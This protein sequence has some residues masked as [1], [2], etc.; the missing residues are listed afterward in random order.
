LLELVE[1]ALDEISLLVKMS[2]VR[3]LNLAVSLWRND[4]L[5]ALPGDLLVQMIGIV[6]FVC[7]SCCR[8]KSVDE[9]V[10]AGDVVFLSWAANEPDWIAKR[11][12]RSM[13]LCAQ[14]ST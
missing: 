3:P 4:N 5:A 11:I 6:T 14:T 8:F 10:R 13:D 9:F 7:E 2:V 1:E 12:A